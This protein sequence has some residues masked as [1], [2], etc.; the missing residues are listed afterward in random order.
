MQH[1]RK[2]GRRFGVD[3]LN[4]RQVTEFDNNLLKHRLLLPGAKV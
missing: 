2:S 4:L 1:K 3:P